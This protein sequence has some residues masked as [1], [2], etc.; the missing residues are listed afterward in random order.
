MA[1]NIE[2]PP[3]VEIEA[4]R[5]EQARMRNPLEPGPGTP[6][7][8]RGS[9]GAIG[10]YFKTVGMSMT[11]PGDL[12]WSMR[13]PETASDTRAFVIICGVM[14]GISWVIHDVIAFVKGGKSFDYYE[15]GYRWAL[16]FVLAAGGTW[17]LLNLITRLFYKLVSAGEM[18]S[19]FPAV[20]LYNVYAYC[21]GPSLLALIPFYV[22]PA[23]AIVW[24]FCLFIYGAIVR[25]YIK[26]SG[27]I[28]CNFIAAGGFLGLAV[29]AYFIVSK[30]LGWLYG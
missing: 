25:L 20:L 27:A 24:I 2:S 12:L 23:I 15:D 30:T 21:L 13:R 9:I 11:R 4:M 8:D 26:S 22:G 17:L 29:A 7:E 10:A 14:W 19:R 28:V 1:K 16:H 5:V 3:G 6:W 18:K